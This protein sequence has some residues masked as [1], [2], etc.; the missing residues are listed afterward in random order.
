MKA[1]D[2]RFFDHAG[3]DWPQIWHS[4]RHEGAQRGASTLSQQLARNLYLSP[5]RSWHRELREAFVADGL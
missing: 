4:V 2:V 1:E 5:E 3:F